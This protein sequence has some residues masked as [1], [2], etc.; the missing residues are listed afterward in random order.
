MKWL[1][2]IVA[3]LVAGAVATF[4]IYTFG[5]EDD[6]GDAPFA[7]LAG[8]VPFSVGSSGM[9][10]TLHCARPAPDCGAD[11][12][13]IVLARP[14]A[15]ATRG[16]IIVYRAPPRARQQC[17]Y[18]ETAIHRVIAL[19]GDLIAVGLDGETTVNGR[20]DSTYVEAGNRG[21]Q[22]GKWR[23]S[24]GYF[25]MGDNRRQSCDSRIWGPVPEGS[26]IGTVKSIDRPS[27]REDVG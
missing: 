5:K 26:L 7:G 18:G 2:G 12:A 17:G 23:I 4:A 6:D 10:P 13:D 25:V 14:T 3:V 1:F 15:R 22:A 16:D 8:V 20:E 19:P 11:V 9:E 27:G 24:G 21:G